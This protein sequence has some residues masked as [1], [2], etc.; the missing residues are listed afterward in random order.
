VSVYTKDFG[1]ANSDAVRLQLGRDGTYF[2][3]EFKSTQSLQGFAM[4]AYQIH[5]SEPQPRRGAR[6]LHGQGQQITFKSSR[7]DK[8]IGYS[9][10]PSQ[11]RLPAA[12]RET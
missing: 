9:P 12:E 4:S 5:L 1:G 8:K 6:H 11:Q 3:T 10:E 2:F 7:I